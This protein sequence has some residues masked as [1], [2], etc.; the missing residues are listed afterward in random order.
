M[1]RSSLIF[2]RE[3]YHERAPARINYLQ[4]NDDEANQVIRTMETVSGSAG[5]LLRR[6]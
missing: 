6:R 3:G 4:G 2:D 1:A 5:A